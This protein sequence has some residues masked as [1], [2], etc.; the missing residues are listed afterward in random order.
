M[1][2]VIF[3]QDIDVRSS[4]K[5]RSEIRDEIIS[6][7]ASIYKAN[8]KELP[9]VVLFSHD[10]RTY[11]LADG[12]HRLQAQRRNGAT[13]VIAEVHKG[14]YEEALAYA[15]VA[16]ERHGIRRS[17][18]DKRQC[19]AEAIKAWPTLPNVQIAQRC[20]VDD[21]TV[22]AVR[23]G[24]EKS[25]EI[26]KEPVRKSADG[27]SIPA[28]TPRKKQPAPPKG[29]DSEIRVASPKEEEDKPKDSI[30]R[31]IPRYCMQYWN[32][33]D[34]IREVLDYLDKVMSVLKKAHQ[35]S[36][37][38]FAEVNVNGTIADLNR[39]WSAIQTAIPYTVCTQCQGHPESQ[40]K[41][42][43]RMCRNRGLISKFLWNNAV[44]AE[45]KQVLKN[46]YK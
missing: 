42:E 15:L 13:S 29:S 39:C 37:P 22:K 44:P 28:S 21:H 46:Q 4:P 3:I 32:R 26:P 38:M 25:K 17:R 6:E 24:M 31:P 30:G 41:K 8:K 12:A 19:V 9:P 16:N 23:D 27:R 20:K 43:C 33:S 35:D 1:S 14:A 34:E 11:L 2:K 5:V 45:M 7:Y 36:D 10:N 18:E 40:P